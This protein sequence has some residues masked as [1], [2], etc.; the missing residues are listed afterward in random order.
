MKLTAESVLN[1]ET[2][3]E[4]APKKVK[5]EKP[6]KTPKVYEDPSPETDEDGD[7]APPVKAGSKAFILIIFI[8]G[9][10]LF[11]FMGYMVLSNLNLSG[12]KSTTTTEQTTEEG[13]TDKETVEDDATPKDERILKLQEENAD[14]KAQLEAEKQRTANGSNYDATIEDLNKQL[15]ETKDALSASE[16]RE[17]ALQEQLGATTSTDKQ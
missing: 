17:K 10:L 16:A 2:V 12:N 15:K 5:K 1:E 13:V 6:A 9:M 8:A 14:L 7:E 11:L 3:Q 4:E